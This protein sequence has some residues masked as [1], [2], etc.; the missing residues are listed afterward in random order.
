MTT[1][2]VLIL[3]ILVL[4]GVIATVGDRIGMRVGKAR[5][6]LFNLRP[7]QTATV[8]SIL[9][10]GVVSG[11][12]LALL[13]AVSDQ[14][15][16]GVFELETLQADLKQARQDLQATQ[17]AKTGV[18]DELA[19]AIR[20]QIRARQRLRNINESLQTA[21]ERQ[22]MTQSQLNQ[23]Q[24]QLQSVSQQA[25]RLRS[26][27]SSLQSERKDLLARQAA[28]R[29]QIAERDQEIAQ[30]DQALAQRN[31]EIVQRDQEIAQRDQAIAQRETRLQK[32]QDQ[33]AY[34]EQ[35]IE[36][37][38]REFLGL[39]QG[40]VAIGRNEPLVARLV[41]V[42]ESVQ[43][44]AIVRRLLQEANWV[45]LQ[46]I[47]PS[48]EEPNQQII[49]ITNAD[50][51]Q[52]T[53]R[54]SD[55]QE[56]IVRFLSAANYVVGEPCVIQREEPCIEVFAN[57]TLNRRIYEQ[58][59]QL[60]EAT[61]ETANPS[62]Q[63]LISRLQLLIAA[64]QFRGSQDGVIDNRVQIAE[65]RSDAVLQFLKQ[66]QTV[67]G[68][69]VMRAIAAEPIFSIGPIRMELVATQQDQILF[70][71]IVPTAAPPSAPEDAATE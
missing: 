66:V 67:D 17:S 59:E 19:T 23:T 48:T 26:E 30:R 60:A 40:S 70:S 58:G 56:Y 52:L 49:R 35:Q 63:E 22:A 31:Q 29:A 8:I 54:I 39:R 71:T 11:T 43:A 34:L 47:D 32:L 42:Q 7:R 65:G 24:K 9:T 3:A 53:N 12:T 15:R 13:F 37:L 55:G 45:A 25:Q 36:Q 62:D 57:A 38:D 64:T 68:S 27:I 20:D 2:Y 61:L 28:V 51:E 41:Q 5:L 6:T 21:V 69:V 50:V 16:T 46:N 10:G 18:E 4:G 33:Q 1:G 14:L 44:T